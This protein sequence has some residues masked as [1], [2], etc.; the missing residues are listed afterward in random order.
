LNLLFEN[1]QNQ[2]KQDGDNDGNKDTGCQREI[3]IAIFTVDNDIS[4]Q[5]PQWKMQGN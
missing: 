1:S 2:I 5:M 4:R 3:K